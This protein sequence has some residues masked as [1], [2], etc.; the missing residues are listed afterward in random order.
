M[1]KKIATALLAIV[2]VSIAAAKIEAAYRN[3]IDHHRNLAQSKG[4]GLGWE[5]GYK[6]GSERA[7]TKCYP[8]VD[9]DA[10]ARIYGPYRIR[11]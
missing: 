1:F 3:H 5:C 8:Y 4:W 10:Y 6:A 7:Y 2:G 11:N 9:K